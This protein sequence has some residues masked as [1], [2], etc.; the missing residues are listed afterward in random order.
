M[1][2]I[3]LM[4]VLCLA[5]VACGKKEEAKQETAETTNVTQKESTQIP[6][7][8]VEVKNLDEASK[9]AGFSLEVP[10]TYEDYKK[11]VIQAIEDDMIEVI[12]YDEN[13]EH[14]GLRIRK[15]K[16]TDDISGDYNEYKDV[17]TVKV[18]DF[19]IIEKGSEGNISVA[20][21]NDGTYSYAIDVAE[22]SLTKDTIAIPSDPSNGGRALILLHNKGVIT[23]KDPKNLFATEFD[24]VKNP[25][26]LKFKPSEVAQL[27]RILPDVTAAIINGNYA[28]QANLSPAKDSLILE[29][30]ESPYANILVVRKG[31][32]KR[33]DI[34][35]LLKALRSE[36]VKKYIN[37]K[38][39]DG[40]VVPAF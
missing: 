31:D 26:K 16:G 5:I 4:S 3:L 6:N 38:Y 22:A 10:E 33:E 19:E 35:K 39:S 15:A 8:F 11:Q 36:K 9:I 14:E 27:P 1:K 12:Y 20:T 30:K 23:L 17:E 34:Q 37:E 18:G 28:L 40:S 7:P 2:K 24:I 25:K 29:G 13:S 32:E 21:W